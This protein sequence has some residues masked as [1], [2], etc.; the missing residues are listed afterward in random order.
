MIESER[1]YALA[2]ST[3]RTGRDDACVTG[4]SICA[5]R[6][7]QADKPTT[8]LYYSLREIAGRHAQGCIQ[9]RNH[10]RCPK[11]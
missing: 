5:R 1:S 9:E 8:R 7:S 4:T 6:T 2:A 10:G 11:N 3:R